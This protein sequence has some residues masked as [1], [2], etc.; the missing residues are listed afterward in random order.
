ME[1]SNEGSGNLAEFERLPVLLLLSLVVS[2]VVVVVVL[3]VIIILSLFVVVVLPPS[4]S[5]FS[6]FVFA[7]FVD[8]RYLSFLLLK[9]GVG[10]MHVPP[11]G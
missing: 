5:L 2:V 7:V 4:A 6:V 10:C 8:V 1:F 9:G 11:S 3:C